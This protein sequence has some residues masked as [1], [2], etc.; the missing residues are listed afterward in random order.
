MN[1]KRC[2]FTGHRPEKL[3]LPESAVKALLKKAIINAVDDG[4]LTF[5]SGM[6]RGV[7]I[8][9]SE[10]VLDLREENSD[11]HLICT[12]PYEGFEKRWSLSE[13]KRYNDILETS[14]FVKFVSR[15]YY[16]ACFQVRNVYMVDHSQ[17]VI[18]A[19]NGSSGGTRNTIEYANR[20]GV[21]VVNIFEE[22]AVK[23]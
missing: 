13:Q 8:W 9:A 7:D 20:K 15:H 14:D 6:A 10:I 23:K 17:M 16:K 22:Y 4:F 19:Y 12:P 18:S 2:C 11:I 21:K 5:I 1:S 3:H